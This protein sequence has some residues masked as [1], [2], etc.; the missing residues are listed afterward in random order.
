[1][2]VAAASRAELFFVRETAHMYASIV[3]PHVA[4]EGPA[5]TAWVRG[6]LN[7]AAEAGDVVHRVVS[8]LRCRASRRDRDTWG[9]DQE[10]DDGFVVVHKSKDVGTSFKCLVLAQ[11]ADLRSLRDVRGVHLPMLRAMRDALATLIGS[12]RFGADVR[13]DTVRVYFHYPPLTYHLHVHATHHRVARGVHVERAHLLDD[14][15]DALGRDGEHFAVAAI[16]Y[17]LPE[18]PLL[19]GLRAAA[20]GGEGVRA[21]AASGGLDA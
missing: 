8:P 20:V 13:W 14:V 15:I 7:G 17:L 1:M 9:A 4:A 2:C 12:G 6:I 18:G 19:E 10:G 3:T 21:V 16:T 5:G 11:R